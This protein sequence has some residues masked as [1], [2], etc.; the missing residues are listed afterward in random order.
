M[1]GDISFLEQMVKSMDELEA[2]LERYY[3]IGDIGNFNKAKKIMLDLQKKI[4][5]IVNDI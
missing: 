4:M 1:E 5:E 3:K 2:R